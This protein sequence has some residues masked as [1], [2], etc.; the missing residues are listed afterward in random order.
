M[1]TITGLTAEAMLAIR[2][3]VIVNARIDAGHLIL[4]K[5]DLSEIDAGNVVGATGLTGLTGPPSI[6]V[7]ADAASRPTTGLFPGL[8]LWQEDVG[9]LYIWDGAAWVLPPTN[10]PHTT[11]TREPVN[12]TGTTDG[13][14]SP[15]ATPL[16]VNFEKFKSDTHFIVNYEG[17]V[18]NNNAFGEYRVGVHVIGPGAIDEYYDLAAGYGDLGPRACTRQIEIAAVGNYIFEAVRRRVN[19]V[20]TVYDGQHNNNRNSLTV[21]ET[22]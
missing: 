21:T 6:V 17:G 13:V 9:L 7:V 15:F 2:D 4:V 14:Y 3:G 1:G 11:C 8:N 20:G 22:Y 18:R 19:G 16:I 10:V 5:Y 12:T